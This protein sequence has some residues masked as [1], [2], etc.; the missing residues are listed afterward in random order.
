M[1]V[2]AVLVGVP[3]WLLY[4]SYDRHV[5]QRRLGVISSEIAGR[6]V[7]VRCPGMFRRVFEWDF[8]QGSVSIDAAGRIADHADLRAEA[9]GELDA[10]ADGRRKDV[11]ACVAAR[12]V[13]GAEAD[14]LAMA[15]DTVTHEAYHLSGILDEADTECHSLNRMAWT[16]ERLGASPAEARELARHLFEAI[17]PLFPER[18]RT[19]PC[20]VTG[21]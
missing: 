16:A 13:C 12:R 1:A 8:H 18:Y 3:A 5:N 4:G 21:Q 14:K 17:Y 15:V 7:T 2:V 20:T 19:P 6:P 9:C 11:L 10:L